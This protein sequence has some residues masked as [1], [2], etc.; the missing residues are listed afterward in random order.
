MG[1]GKILYDT[2]NRGRSVVFRAVNDGT[3]GNGFLMEEGYTIVAS[4]WQAPYP[5]S[6]VPQIFVGLGSRLPVDTPMLKA[7]LPIARNSDGSP[8][9]GMSRELYYNTILNIPGA[10][11]AF[12]KHLTYPA[13]TL[14]KCRARLTVRA[15]E[16]EIPQ[17]WYQ[18]GSISTSGGLRLRNRPVTMAVLFM[19]S[20]IRQK[21]PLF[22]GWDLSAFGTWSPFCA[23]Q[24][25][26]TRETRTP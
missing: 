3:P 14:D 8:V 2:L 25:R 1:I 19:N 21:S 23:M 7:R 6:G 15:N 18:I 16:R 12:V 5:V 17:R 9:I 13:A 22:T 11:G 26:T 24:A 20:L 4:G 10:D